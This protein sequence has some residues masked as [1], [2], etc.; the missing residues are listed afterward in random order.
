MMLSIDEISTLVAESKNNQTLSI[1]ELSVLLERNKH[2]FIFYS[3]YGGMG[4]EF[5]LKYLSDNVPT[6]I[7]QRDSKLMEDF[8]MM[9]WETDLSTGN[10]HYFADTIF[11]HYFLVSGMKAEAEDYTS[12]SNF[13]ELAERI[14]TGLKSDCFGYPEHDFNTLL[15]LDKHEDKRYLIKLHNLYDEVKLFKDA[16]VINTVPSEWK[17]HCQVLCRVKNETHYVYTRDDKIRRIEMLSFLSEQNDPFLEHHEYNWNSTKSSLETI[18]RY[19]SDIIEND[20]VPLYNNTIYMALQPSNYKLDMKTTSAEEINN[21]AT[22]RRLYFSKFTDNSSTENTTSSTDT[23]VYTFND[24][25]GGEWISQEFDLDAEKFRKTFDD[26]FDKNIELLNKFGVDEH[27][28]PKNSYTP[29]SKRTIRK[30]IGLVTRYN[31][32]SNTRA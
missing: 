28:I 2:K 32:G 23:S 13:D 14:L 22:L 18:N 3:Y 16:K 11:C 4:G 9:G 17:T 19:L 21:T 7:N 24:I 6:I 10:K 30:P 26:W 15:E 1:G 8:Y 29:R 27:Y 31:N 20:D 12:A 25:A 5:I